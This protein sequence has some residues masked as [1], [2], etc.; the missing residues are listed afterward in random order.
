MVGAWSMGY[1]ERTDFSKANKDSPGPGAYN[2]DKFD[3]FQKKMAKFSMGK[4]KRKHISKLL[5]QNTPGPGHYSIER[6]IN[7]GSK[8]SFGVKHQDLNKTISQTTPGPG[9]YSPQKLPKFSPKFTFGSKLDKDL[10]TMK[11]V[12]GSGNYSIGSMVKHPGP[13]SYNPND[14]TYSLI[15][16]SPHFRFASSGRNTCNRKQI[17]FPGPGNYNIN[18]ELGKSGPSFSMSLK[19]KITKSIKITKD[20]PGPGNYSPNNSFTKKAPP[21]VS[22]GSRERF[23]DNRNHVNKTIDANETSKS[24]KSAKTLKDST[25]KTAPSFSFGSSSRPHP[26]DIRDLPGPGQY[27]VDRQVNEGRKFQFGIRLKDNN[28]NLSSPGP[29]NYNPKVDLAKTSDPK[30]GIGSSQRELPSKTGGQPGPGSYEPDLVN[31]RDKTPKRG[32]FGKEDRLR[33]VKSNVP[34]PGSYKIP[35]RTIEAP[36]YLVKGE[37]KY[38]YV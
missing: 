28:A 15:K 4:D 27:T 5:F 34:G 22:F 17:N 30:F 3:P 6:K 21:G 38:E 8:Y 1:G 29:G 37:E 36:K 16:K 26:G 2:S 35:T 20:T 14:Q 7:K 31:Y 18:R 19:K 9:N 33:R 25:K 10:S 24:L 23:K 32:T 11:A 13:G 12:P